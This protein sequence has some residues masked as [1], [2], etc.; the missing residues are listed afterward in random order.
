ML[1]GCCWRSKPCRCCCCPFHCCCSRCCCCSCSICCCLWFC[2]PFCSF[3]TCSC[4]L[5]PCLRSPLAPSASSSSLLSTSSPLSTSSIIALISCCNSAMSSSTPTSQGGLDCRGAGGPAVG[6][7]VVGPTTLG[8]RREWCCSAAARARW[9]V[10]RCSCRRYGSLRQGSLCCR[11]ACTRTMA[12][13]SCRCSWKPL[14]IIVSKPVLDH[15]FR[16]CSTTATNFSKLL[17]CV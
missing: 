6:R 2:C 17:A 9:C 13:C 14:A 8:L 12:G 3:C 15:D 1:E 11:D 5:A 10:G 4:I 7:S 16:V